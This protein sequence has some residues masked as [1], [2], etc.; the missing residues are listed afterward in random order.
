MWAAHVFLWGRT[1]YQNWTK[2]KEFLGG[3]SVLTMVAAVFPPWPSR[4]LK[5][6]HVLCIYTTSAFYIASDDQCWLN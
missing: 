4:R 3:M 1:E 6:V 2:G 5:P